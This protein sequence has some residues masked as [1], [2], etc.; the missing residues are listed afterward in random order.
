[1]SDPYIKTE[2]GVARLLREYAQHQSLIVAVDFDDTVF[3]YHKVGHTYERVWELLKRCQ[4]LGFH[5]VLFTGTH[6]DK[7]Q[8]QIDYMADHGITVAPKVNA[9][10]IDLPFGNYGKMYYNILLDDRAGLGQACDILTL[11][12]DAIEKGTAQ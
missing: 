1:M 7:W 8:S 2:F 12:L 4:Q 5:L 9:N 6:M 11:T 10:P 3:D